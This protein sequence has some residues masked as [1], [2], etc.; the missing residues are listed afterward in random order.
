MPIIPLLANAAFD[1]EATR[2]LGRAFDDAW[3]ILQASDGSLANA[4]DAALARQLLAKCVMEMARRGERS[5][6]RLIN[7]AIARFRKSS[8]HGWC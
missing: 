4:S 6:G 8:S 7:N 2:F 5:R 1:T 3:K